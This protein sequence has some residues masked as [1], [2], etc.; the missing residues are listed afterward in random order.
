MLLKLYEIKIGQELPSRVKLITQEEIDLY[1]KAS[2][3]F[4]PIH[5]DPVFARQ[6]SAKGT[7]VHG[8]LVLA[9][10]SQMM[11]DAFGL[12]W[13]A[14]GHFNI[15]FKTPAKPGDMLTIR[16]KV[17]KIVREQF[18]IGHTTLQMECAGD[19]SRMCGCGVL[20]SAPKN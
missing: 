18:R 19:S 14:G 17:E 15:R 20:E 2:H 5:I 3:D 7:I 8:M 9:Y 11:T 4:N 16:G 1:A 10:I 13:L 12:N 6:T